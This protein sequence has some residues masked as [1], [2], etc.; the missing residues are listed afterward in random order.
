MRNHDADSIEAAATRLVEKD[1]SAIQAD[2]YTDD[3]YAT[4]CVANCLLANPYD[5]AEC[6]RVIRELQE[7]FL[8]SMMPRIEIERSKPALLRR[9]FNRHGVYE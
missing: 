1:E 4:G 3:A 6:Q 7:S 8:V 9:I 2:W 5:A